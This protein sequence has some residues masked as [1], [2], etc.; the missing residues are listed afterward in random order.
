M[1]TTLRLPPSYSRVVAPITQHLKRKQGF[2]AK[3]AR[4]AKMAGKQQ[5]IKSDHHPVSVLTHGIKIFSW[6]MLAHTHRYNQFLNIQEG[7]LIFQARQTAGQ[8]RVH[9]FYSKLAAHLQETLKDRPELQDLTDGRLLSYKDP[10]IKRALFDSIFPT[11]IE[12]FDTVFQEVQVL[13]SEAEFEFL[14]ACGEA[15]Y[16][17]RSIHGGYLDIEKRRENLKSDTLLITKMREHEILTLQECYDPQTV[18]KLINQNNNRYSLLRYQVPSKNNSNDDNC[19]IIYDHTQWNLENS[20]SFALEKKKPCILA[21]FTS[22]V[23]PSQKI[24]VGSIHHPGA[25]PA[26]FKSYTLEILDQLKNLGPTFRL[27]DPI[28]ILG[29]FNATVQS[30]SHANH[31]KQLKSNFNFYPPPRPTMRGLDHNRFFT[32]IDMCW[33]N[34]LKTNSKNIDLSIEYEDIKK[35]N[36]TN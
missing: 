1:A 7:P 6:N 29:D 3:N 4:A 13:G 24:N 35:G 31:D 33:S 15:L 30:H 36:Q 28:A 26:H 16:W 12:D 25:K 5:V 34:D 18:L 19:C 27:R 22:R 17:D 32:A 2:S 10:D 9:V 20:A 21:I 14:V 8:T 23:D 11:G